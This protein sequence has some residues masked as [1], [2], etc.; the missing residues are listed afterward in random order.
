MRLFGKHSF[1]CNRHCFILLQ[2]YMFLV[3]AIQRYHKNVLRNLQPTISGFPIK[4]MIHQTAQNMLF[5]YHN[6]Q[7][8]KILKQ[9]LQCEM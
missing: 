2:E 9:T 6:L 3:H 5:F 1:A 8:I 7:V 4:G